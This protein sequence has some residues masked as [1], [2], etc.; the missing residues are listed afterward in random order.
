MDTVEQKKALRALIKARKKNLTPQEKERQAKV[1]AEQ[2]WEP[3]T[4]GLVESSDYDTT[5][6]YWA[7]PDELPTHDIINQLLAYK[8]RVVLPVVTG[9]ELEL[10]EYTGESCLQP[11]P[12]FGILEPRGTARVDPAEIGIAIIPG[13][14]FDEDWRR[15]GRGRGYYDRLFPQMPQAY[16]IGVCFAEQ[17]VDC[18]PCEPHDV[19]MDWLCYENK[20]NHR[21]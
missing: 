6:C 5:L 13:V 14:A 16:K 21:K 3:V 2:I 8:K 18:V 19:T 4:Y 7:L 11:Q 1:V 9:D 10:F 12:P 15:L 20:K 17:I